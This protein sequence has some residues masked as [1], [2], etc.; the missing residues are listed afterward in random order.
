MILIDTHI[1]LRW[2]LP[3]DPLPD[4]FVL[5]IEQANKIRVSSMSCWEVVMLEQRQ[6]KKEL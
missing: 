6:I 1:G 5:Q 2:L 4:S 3:T